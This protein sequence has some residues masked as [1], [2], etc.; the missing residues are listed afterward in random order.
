MDSD[1]ESQDSDDGRRF[2]FEATRKD[3]VQQESK[4]GKQSRSKSERDYGHNDAQHEDKRNRIE[5]SDFNK[6]APGLSKERDNDNRDLKHS[7]KYLKHSLESRSSRRE[8]NKNYRSA[9]DVSSNSKNSPLYS[10]H[11]TKDTKRYRSR[12][13]DEHRCGRSQERCRSKNENEKSQSEKY[14]NKSHERYKHYTSDKNR[15]K[16]YQSN[17]VRS[18]DLAKLRG[19]K[20]MKNDEGEHLQ[21]RTSTK[22]VEQG[23]SG[24]ELLAKGDC[25]VESQEYKELNLSEFDILS[26][27]DENMS[28]DSDV[29]IESPLL[30]QQNKKAEKRNLDSEYENSSKKQAI[31]FEALEGSPKVNARKNDELYGSSN[32]NSGTISDSTLGTTSP[33]L[34]ESR[35]STIDLNSEG[36]TL[37]TTEN[38]HTSLHPNNYDSVKDTDNEVS[39]SEMH[40]ERNTTYGPLL[41]PQLTIN[42]PDNTGKDVQFIGP[43]LPR[44]D[45]QGMNERIEEDTVN[46]ISRDSV[47]SNEFDS[48]LNMIFGPALPPH[49]L[50]QKSNDETNTKII[51]S[52]LPDTINTFNNNAVDQTESDN[53]DGIGPLPPNHPALESNYVYRQLEQRAQQMKNEQRDEVAK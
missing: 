34:T 24:D 11:K 2:R 10:K 1:S 50:T 42:S 52:T 26:E 47:I 9:K 19:I 25:S 5:N 46:C 18:T 7:A 53:D 21:E 38:T 22:N 44:N 40:V 37:I 20:V 39:L 43:C 27:T 35:K 23:Q 17:K 48:D 6:G 3:N 36:E 41:P 15:D 32:N 12:D 8:D 30:R 33:I 29:K 13:R 45:V 16:N 31:E 28:D 14:R 49:L 51:D 4:L